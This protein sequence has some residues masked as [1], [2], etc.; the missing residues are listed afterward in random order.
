MKIGGKEFTVKIT[1][2]VLNDIEKSFGNGELHG[3]RS[4]S[5]ILNDVASFS[6]IQMGVIIWHSIKSEITYDEFLDEILP[7]QYIGAIK[8]VLNEINNAFGL[9]LKKK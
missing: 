9:D 3:E 7:S 6:T 4:M 8:E 5:S 2:R 1:N